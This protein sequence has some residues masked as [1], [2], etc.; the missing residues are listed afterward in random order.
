M[1]VMPRR[2]RRLKMTVD[3]VD[4]VPEWAVQELT[5]EM[6]RTCTRFVVR[7]LIRTW[8]VR[9][10]HARYI[11]DAFFPARSPNGIWWMLRGRMQVSHSEGR[12]HVVLR[13]RKRA[14]GW[15]FG[16]RWRRKRKPLLAHESAHLRFTPKEKSYDRQDG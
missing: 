6:H 8:D 13:I 1:G 10:T 5:D 15:Y 7:D 2:R 4:G 11:T 14:R 3:L 9:D 12:S 16:I